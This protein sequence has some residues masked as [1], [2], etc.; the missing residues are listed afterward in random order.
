MAHNGGFGELAQLDAQLGPTAA[1]CA[2]TPT[3]NGISR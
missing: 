2:E 1:W 3:P